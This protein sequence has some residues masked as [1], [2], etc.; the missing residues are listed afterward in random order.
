MMASPTATSA[1]AT[2]I[3][4]NTKTCPAGSERYDENATKSRFTALS[5]N[6]TD[7]KIIMAFRRISTPT[8]PMINKI[9]ANN[10]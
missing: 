1:A 9:L 4:K 5:I 8:M 3:M 2:A 7:I 10:T 6:S